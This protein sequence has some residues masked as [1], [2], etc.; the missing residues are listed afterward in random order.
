MNLQILIAAIAL[1]TETFTRSGLAAAGITPD[2]WEKLKQDTLWTVN[3]RVIVQRTFGHLRDGLAQVQ[4]FV[5][6][7]VPAEYIAAL[8]CY[9]VSPVNYQAACRWFHDLQMQAA[10]ALAPDQG[11]ESVKPETLFAFVLQ[12]YAQ[13]EAFRQKHDA[14]VRKQS[15]KA[16]GNAA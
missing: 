3:D 7:Q 15:Q 11:A 8:I 13:T 12:A 14:A 1:A 10:E 6:F 4:G 2:D 5:P 16:T 9:S